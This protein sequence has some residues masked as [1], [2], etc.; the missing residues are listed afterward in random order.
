MLDAGEVQRGQYLVGLSLNHNDPA[1]L[2][3]AWS[4][5]KL[6]ECLYRLTNIAGKLA[7]ALL[8]QRLPICLAR[9]KLGWVRFLAHQTLFLIISSVRGTKKHNSAKNLI[10]PRLPERI[11]EQRICFIHMSLFKYHSTVC[12]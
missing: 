3:T 9:G 10:L 2:S 12:T 7:L 6:L 4:E 5:G 8:D 1:D 11:L